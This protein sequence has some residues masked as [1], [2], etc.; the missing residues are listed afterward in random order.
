[1]PSAPPRPCR[2]QGCRALVQGTVGYCKAHQRTVHAR[3]D[4]DRG[5][6]SARGYGHAW[7]TRVRPAALAREPLCRFCLEQGRTVQATE[8][9]HVDGNSRNNDPANLRCLCHACHSRRTATDQAWGRGRP[10]A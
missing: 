5:N 8:V 4:R 1:M 6:S 10:V 2:E 9:D 7:R 3:V